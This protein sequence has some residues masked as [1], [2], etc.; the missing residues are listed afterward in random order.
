MNMIIS[1]HFECYFTAAR[2]EK[3]NSLL[4]AVYILTANGRL[5]SDAEPCVSRDN[6][7][8][9]SIKRGKY[10]IGAYALFC[11][12]KDLYLGTESMNIADMSDRSVIPD[13]AFGLI[14]NAMMIKRYGL[15]A[16]DLF[17]VSDEALNETENPNTTSCDGGEYAEKEAETA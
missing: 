11:A 13:A 6:I 4:A 17:N 10:S 5:W 9:D 14:C 8:F 12:A 16:L 3:S 7:D 2:L 15:K 1:S